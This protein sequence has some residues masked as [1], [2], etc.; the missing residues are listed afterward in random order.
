MA[1]KR[2]YHTN[3]PMCTACILLCLTLFS[4]HLSGGLYARYTTKASASDDAR[5][6][7]FDVSE[8]GSSFSENMMIDAIPG[9]VVENTINVINKSEVAVEYVV[10][11]TNTTENIPLK[12]TVNDSEPTEGTC[13]VTVIMKPNSTHEVKLAAVW[14]ADNAI[15]YMGMVDLVEITINAQQQD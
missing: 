8:N 7:S 1:N 6:A 10:T 5:V 13:T 2:R 14:D 3:I 12:F 4:F 9:S 15:K 11:I